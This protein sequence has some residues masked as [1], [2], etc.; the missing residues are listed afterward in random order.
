MIQKRLIYVRLKVVPKILCH[1]LS[2]DSQSTDKGKH[3]I[4]RLTQTLAS[5]F[6]LYLN[7]DT[8]NVVCSMRITNLNPKIQGK[9]SFCI[10]NRKTGRENR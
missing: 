6:T 4:F 1:K 2:T 3:T 8:G 9:I 10:P 7:I 5:R